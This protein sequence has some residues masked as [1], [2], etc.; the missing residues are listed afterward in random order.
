MFLSGWSHCIG[1]QGQI[2][3]LLL[4]FCL[5]VPPRAPTA[6]ELS[7]RCGGWRLALLYSFAGNVKAA[8]HTDL[9]H[10]MDI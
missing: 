5:L 8:S 7:E 6:R 2:L 1:P 10:S 3:H 9:F 4:G